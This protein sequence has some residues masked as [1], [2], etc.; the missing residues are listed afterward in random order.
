MKHELTFRSRR[1]RPAH[2]QPSGSE[3][4]LGIRILGGLH[5]R[6][7]RILSFR[8]RHP[9]IGHAQRLISEEAVRTRYLLMPKLPVLLLSSPKGTITF[10]TKRPFARLLLLSKNRIRTITITQRFDELC[11]VGVVPETDCTRTAASAIAVPSSLA[12]QA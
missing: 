7:A 3:T 1:M 8:M 4:L 6:Y 5:H 2:A 12:M 10:R 9:F 11:V